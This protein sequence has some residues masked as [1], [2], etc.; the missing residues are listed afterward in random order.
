MV[1]EW[2]SGEWSVWLV[3]AGVAERRAPEVVAQQLEDTG[4]AQDVRVACHS[5][6]VVMY[7]LAEQ[8][9]RVA[10]ERDAGHD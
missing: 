1:P 2:E 5:H 10:R 3:A 4:G 6:Y 7:E 8:G 9:V